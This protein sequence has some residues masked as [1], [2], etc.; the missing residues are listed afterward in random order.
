VQP[1]HS[2]TDLLN[3]LRIGTDLVGKRSLIWQFTRREVIG[4]YRGAYLGVL[5]SFLNPLLMLAVYTVVFGF[6]FKGSFGPSSSGTLDFALALFCGLNIFNLFGE[7][8]ARSPMLIL[9]NPNYVTKVVFPLEILPVAVIGGALVHLLIAMLPL[10]LG[11][12]FLHGGLPLTS[13]FLVLLLVP[14]VL[15]SLGCSWFLA[16]F[17]VFVR[18]VNSLLTSLI[19][20]LMFMSAVFYP[21]EAVP[22]P[23]RY[24]V[25]FNPLAALIAQSRNVLIAGI[26]LNWTVFLVLLGTSLVVA[27]GGYA[28][29]IRTKPAFP[30]VM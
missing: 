26:G 12:L 13:I 3:P 5:W 19:L 15:Y 18:D 4:R 27:V 23:F 21:V 25:E 11:I 22:F 17:G 9:S 14:L 24:I 2:L 30:D 1:S 10:L 29:F 8:L 28:F 7:S 16:S 6:I 20:V